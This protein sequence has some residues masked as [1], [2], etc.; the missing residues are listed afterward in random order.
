VNAGW[1]KG[2]QEPQFTHPPAERTTATAFAASAQAQSFPSRPIKLV[3]PFPPG[4]TGDVQARIIGDHMGRTLGQP[5]VVENKA[6]GGT[7][8]GTAQVAKAP[9][10]GHTLLLM[11]NSFVINAKLHASSLPYDGLK[12]F[13]PVA[14]L[15]NSP[16]MLAVNSASPYRS[17]KEWM[18]AAKARPDTISYSTFGPAS[19]QH[20]AAEMLLRAA[21]IRLIYA[22]FAGGAPAVNA[23]LAG[24]V[25]TVLANVSE[26]QSFV[27]AGKLRALAVTTPQRLDSLKGLPTVAE[28]GLPGYEASAWFGLCA[29]AG[30]PKEAV[31][32]LARAASLAL[33]DAE[34]RKKLVGIGLEPYPMDS[35]QFGAHIA[36]QFARYS[37]VID[38]AGIKA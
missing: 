37:R 18:E 8:I 5:V 27:D 11:A 29:P 12:A 24:H 32:R 30:T 19:T 21:G 2:G 34:I 25:D 17:F 28:S 26:I 6:G 31:A 35:A 33:A 3:V 38:E 20:I 13:E 16:Q 22:P 7:V 15:T 1:G 4:G 14:C 10:D 23:V 9:A 36:D